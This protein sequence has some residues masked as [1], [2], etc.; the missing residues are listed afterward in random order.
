VKHCRR[1]LCWA[2][3]QSA[4]A[5][6]A[7][8]HRHRHAHMDLAWLWPI[9]ETRRKC[10]AFFHSAAYDGAL[11]DYVFGASQPTIRVVK[12]DYPAFTPASR[13]KSLKDDGKRR[14]IG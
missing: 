9:R 1:A 5:T 12:E 2:E 4:E 13:R 10:G 8:L 11:P 6:F 3:L 14:R 7:Y